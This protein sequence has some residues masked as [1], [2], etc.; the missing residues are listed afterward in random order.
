V[1]PKKTEAVLSR[2]PRPL[3]G[4]ISLSDAEPTLWARGL[5]LVAPFASLGLTPS[6]ASEGSSHP[7]IP[8]HLRPWQ[9]GVLDLAD[10]VP[11]GFDAADVTR[12]VD[13]AFL[14]KMP[15]V[16]SMKRALVSGGAPGCGKTRMQLRLCEL[17]PNA[18]YF[19]PDEGFLF[20]MK[21]HS[22]SRT[23]AERLAFYERYRA[24]SQYGSMMILNRATKGG[25][26]LIFDSTLQSDMALSMLGTLKSL[27]YR[28]E[29][30]S[31]CAPLDVSLSRNHARVN[32]VPDT[33][34]RAK[35]QK[36]F[37]QIPKLPRVADRF[38]L[39]WNPSNEQEPR[40]AITFLNG[41]V[42]RSSPADV[43]AIA[44]D[45]ASESP[46][47]STWLLDLIHVAPSDNS[48]PSSVRAP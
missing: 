45:V 4:P 8:T 14:G 10:Q 39:Y 24:V 27:G 46:S 22:S 26:D 6:T 41:A 38:T 3:V 37:E 21:G 13:A 40:P 48:P 34:V 33:D 28:I 36:F 2:A 1:V 7:L 23:E 9:R 19:N 47:T 17:Y 11:P 29:V 12:I 44:A 15:V 43:R 5:S 16:P 35:R 18:V 20:H 42:V 30:D 32:T 31:M 25:Y